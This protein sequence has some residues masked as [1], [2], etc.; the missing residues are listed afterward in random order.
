MRES[1]RLER[2][3]DEEEARLEKVENENQARLSRVENLLQRVRTGLT[4]GDDANDDNDKLIG[5]R[6]DDRTIGVSKTI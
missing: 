4:D 3:V 6:D 2:V 1:L 5:K